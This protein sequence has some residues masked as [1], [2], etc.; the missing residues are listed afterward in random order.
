[1]SLELTDG[2]LE[3]ILK[4]LEKDK[5]GMYYSGGQNRHIHTKKMALIARVMNEIDHRRLRG[6]KWVD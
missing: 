5:D 1:M 6:D 2:D 4:A 3:L